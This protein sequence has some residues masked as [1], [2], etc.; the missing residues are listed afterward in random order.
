MRVRSPYYNFS[1]YVS[2]FFVDARE[3]Q[4]CRNGALRGPSMCLRID[5]VGLSLEC[6][7]GMT[8]SMEGFGWVQRRFG[9]VR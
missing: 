8:E 4:R 7:R 9:I 2:T 3:W 1:S 5:R 6:S